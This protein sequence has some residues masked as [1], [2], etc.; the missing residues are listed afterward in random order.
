MNTKFHQKFILAT[1]MYH[2]AILIIEEQPD[3]AYLNLVSAIEA[4]CQD[5]PIGSI[6]LRDVNAGLADAV[7][8]I[9]DE[10]VR[11]AVA[12]AAIKKERFIGRRFINFIVTGRQ[13][14]SGNDL[15]D[16]IPI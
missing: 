4:L 5:E 1:K 14:P 9:Q 15:T 6:S 2:Q 13:M 7:D 11:K 8:T 3:I 12:A 10:E 16:P